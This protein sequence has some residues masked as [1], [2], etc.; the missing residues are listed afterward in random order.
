MN[1]RIKKKHAFLVVN[2][3]TEYSLR[4]KYPKTFIKKGYKQMKI[5]KDDPKFFM[6]RD[7]HIE[8]ESELTPKEKAL[9]CQVSFLLTEEDI[10]QKQAIYDKYDGDVIFV[11]D[12]SF[13]KIMK[14]R[15][16]KALLKQM[17]RGRRNG[18]KR[19]AGQIS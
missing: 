11:S 8:R 2:E 14:I 17:K 3:A 5:I 9:I 16:V 1:K 15:G 10:K 6:K 4:I 19:R 12:E 13:D 18:N 7:A